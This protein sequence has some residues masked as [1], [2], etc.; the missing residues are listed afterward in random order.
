MCFDRLLRVLLFAFC[1][2]ALALPAR[3]ETAGEVLIAVGDV[4][5]KRA[6]R[7]LRLSPKTAIES[8]DQIRTGA[9]SNVQIRF[10]DTGLVSIRSHSD[11]VID[12]YSYKGRD[13][14]FFSL[15]K[16]GARFV[17]GLIGRSDQRDYMVRVPTAVVG[18]R[19]THFSLVVCRSECRDSDGK[20]AAEGL[21]GGVIEGRI[22]VT[23]AGNKA[24]EREFGAGE[25]FHLASANSAPAPLSAPPAFLDDK[26]DKPARHARKKDV[27]IGDRP[28]AT[29]KADPGAAP[30][31]DAGR[32]SAP[33]PK[34]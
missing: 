2:A 27:E 21:Y 14:A 34:R 8:G 30:P 29:G 26:L 5:A 1:S 6:G 11:F 22:A 20:P 10:T 25:F 16:G 28:N 23:P 32:P 19:G 12:E 3:A 7:T 13:K 15:L 31:R 18:I 33:P 24:L 4:S 9:E 17:T